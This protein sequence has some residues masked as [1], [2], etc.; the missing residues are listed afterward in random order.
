MWTLLAGLSLAAS[1]N[2]P[3]FEYARTE[4]GPDA[5][6]VTFTRWMP[7]HVLHAAVPVAL[8]SGPDAPADGAKVP[9]DGELTIVT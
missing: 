2:L 3:P 8:R 6:A 5:G 4:G 1:D 9:A 7:G